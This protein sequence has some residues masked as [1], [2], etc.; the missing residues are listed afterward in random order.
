M[1]TYYIS[2]NGSDTNDGLTP[3]TPWQ[4]IK[5]VNSS[6]S[7]GDTVC[8]RRGDIFFGQI[9][10]PKKN[11]TD[12]KTAYTSYGEGTKP[13]VSQ[14]KTAR[15]DAWEHFADGVWRIDL[16]DVNKFDGN[17]TELDTNV[18]FMK[19]DGT[20]KPK[21]Y[22]ELDKLEEQWDFY[23]DKQYVYVKS[24]DDPSLLAKDIKFACNIIHLPFVDNLLVEDIIFIGSGSHGISGTV[25]HATVRN[26]EF[27]ELG[28]SELTTHFRPCVRYGNGLECWTDSSDVLV[29]N[30]RFSNIYDVALT[31]QGNNV[32]RGW[33][34]M[35]FRGNVIWN[36]QQGFEI[37]SN[38]ELENT[39]FQNCVFENNVCIDSGYSWGHIVRGNKHC[40]SHLLIYQT[41]CPLCDVTVRNNTFYNAR[42]APIF[43]AGGPQAMPKDYKITGNLFLI[44]PNQDVILRHKDTTDE[45]YQAFYEKI[46][47]DNQIVET[48]FYTPPKNE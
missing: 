40:S 18:G 4:T 8:F 7:G 29:E 16:T 43:K 12:A 25:N 23:N 10:A 20:I 33:V 13:I 41:E 27:H 37:W 26:C 35:T 9:R 44:D 28:G 47:K 31:M 34:N 48:E 5:K 38:G 39:G 3:Q 17:V 32:T 14:Y 22:F 11:D 36:C 2:A 21:K 30:C 19:V 24:A 6:V 42:V 46:A 15:Y 45:E 1:S